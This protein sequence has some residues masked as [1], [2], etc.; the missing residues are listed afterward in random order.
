MNKNYRETTTTTTTITTWSVLVSS[1]VHMSKQVN[2]AKPWVN[3]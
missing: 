2:K 1:V 3:K